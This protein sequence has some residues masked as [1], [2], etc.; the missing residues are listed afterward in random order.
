MGFKVDACGYSCPEPVIRLKRVIDK[1]DEIDLLVDNRTSTE[2]CGRF[3]RSKGFTV[4]TRREDDIY[5][6]EIRKAAD[7]SV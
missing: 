4:D 5:I 1:H 6:L 2:I 7:M 3:A